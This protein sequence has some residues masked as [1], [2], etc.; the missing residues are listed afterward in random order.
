M[1]QEGA[2]L[3]LDEVTPREYHSVHSAILTQPIQHIWTYLVSE[4]V[5]DFGDTYI[6]LTIEPTVEL[7]LDMV[8]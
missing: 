3:S 2:F 1:R 6:I 4:V 8:V 7:S 5:R